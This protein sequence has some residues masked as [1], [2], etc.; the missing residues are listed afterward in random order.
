[1]SK[2]TFEISNMPDFGAYGK[3]VDKAINKALDEIADD[4]LLTAQKRA[5]VD[6]TDLE[7]SGSRTAV[8]NFEVEV[9]F[10]AKN[11]GYNYARRMDQDIYNLGKESKRKAGSIKS[12]FAKSSMKVGPGYLTDT[13]EKS[14]KGYSEHI[15]KAVQKQNKNIKSN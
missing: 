8:K 7:R 14:K 13:A 5:P 3:N 12:K 4:L 10:S 2:F 11:R 9:S 15:E 1:M 6:S